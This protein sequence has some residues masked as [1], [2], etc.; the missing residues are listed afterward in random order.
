MSRRADSL[1]FLF[2]VMALSG[3]ASNLGGRVDGGEDALSPEERR[4]QALETKVAEMNRRLNALNTQRFDEDNQKLRDDM[5]S[6]RGEMEKTR[7]D[8]QQQEKRSKDLYMDLDRRLQKLESQPAAAAGS[9]GYAIAP[10]TEAASA[11]VTAAPQA[12]GTVTAGGAA[13]ISAPLASPEEEGAYLATFDLLKNGK[14]DEAIRGFRA[15]L[16]KWPTGRYADNAA[17][18]MGEANYVKRDYGAAKSAFQTVLQNYPGSAK[19]PDAMLKL[20]LTYNELK[21]PDQS[22]ATLEQLIQKYPTSNAAKLA[23]QR[24]STPNPPP[25][26]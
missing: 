16:D 15:M 6:L 12:A 4:L 1:A 13:V 23:A 7:F 21:Q 5:R 24:L 8:S 11:G 17:Y 22:K 18:W 10:V 14:Y 19:A 25:K 26:R 20:G 2:A 3:C 9:S